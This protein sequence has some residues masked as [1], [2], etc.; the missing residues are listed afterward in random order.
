MMTRKETYEA[1][2]KFLIENKDTPTAW[3]A[4]LVR[5]FTD[6]LFEKGCPRLAFWTWRMANPA[7]LRKG[8][9]HQTIGDILAD[10]IMNIREIPERKAEYPVHGPEFEYRGALRRQ[11]LESQLL[12]ERP[13]EGDPEERGIYEDTFITDRPV[14][15]ALFD[16]TVTM[17]AE[18]LIGMLSQIKRNP[19]SFIRKYAN[20]GAWNR[21]NT[22]KRRT[23]ENV[24]AAIE[25]LDMRR[26]RTCVV[27]GNAF[28]S[29]S[30]QPGRVKLCEI[31]VHP[32]FKAKFFCQVERDR[33][34]A[35]L[36]KHK[37]VAA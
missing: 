6:E 9:P 26:V 4:E 18:H 33:A 31:M 15:S 16:E 34:L 29:H 10:Y 3:R 5:Q 1:V 7:L 8:A 13:D 2:Q 28:Y 23:P 30:P 36:R 11:A 32:Q 21:D 20:G 25:A 19:E 35:V 14:E 17:A 22:V 37:K 24:R 27:C 12:T